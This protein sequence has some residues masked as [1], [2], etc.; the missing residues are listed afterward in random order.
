MFY[1]WIFVTG[2]VHKWT[3]VLAA[4]TGTAVI[5]VVSGVQWTTVLVTGV[6]AVATAFGVWSK[7]RHERADKNIERIDAVTDRILAENE[8]L[9][10]R[11]SKLEIE[12]EAERDDR[13]RYQD[14]AR[15]LTLQLES[16]GLVPDWP[17][18]PKEK[19]LV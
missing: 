8:Q 16:N 6:P 18:P 9:R 17:P 2:V 5:A 11:L 10:D 13:W 1:V 3:V 12:L 19:T 15:R 14:G 4:A 7:T